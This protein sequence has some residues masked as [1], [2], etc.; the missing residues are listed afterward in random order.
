[1]ADIASPKALTFERARKGARK[2]LVAAPRRRRFTVFL[3]KGGFFVFP[4][5]WAGADYSF[6][7]AAFFVF[8]IVFRRW[9][10]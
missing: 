6:F 9:L 8:S 4:G 5:D 2:G 10:L 3:P 7:G 1:L